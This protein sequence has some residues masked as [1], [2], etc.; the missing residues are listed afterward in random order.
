[1]SGVTYAVQLRNSILASNLKALQYVGAAALSEDHNIVFRPSVYDPV[2][3][4]VGGYRFSGHD[5]NIGRWTMLSNQGEGTLAIDPLFMDAANADFRVAPTSAAVGRGA[6]M[7]GA[8][9]PTNLGLY[10]EPV[11]P[12]NHSPWADAGRNR[13]GRKNR[14]L[15]F[16]A[17]G[18][19]DPDGDALS[20][21]WDFGDGSIPAAG[22]SASHVYAAPGQYAVTLTVSDGFSSGQAT[23]QA[24]I[25]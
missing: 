7:D 17:T 12:V 2:I 15:S 11:G 10:Q 20:Y 13:R 22:F 4:Q 24:T 1:V 14:K 5:V 3:A 21:S 8:A 23:I 9:L 19:L 6:P 16:T 25:R 18:S